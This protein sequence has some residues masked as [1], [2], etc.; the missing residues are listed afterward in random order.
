MNEKVGEG[1][2][3]DVEDGVE[4]AVKAV[5]S[6]ERRA[7]EEVVAPLERVSGDNAANCVDDD[8]DDNDDAV[9]CVSAVT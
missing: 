4:M 7:V 1:D 9:I 2:E 6:G 5:D 8:E 3:E